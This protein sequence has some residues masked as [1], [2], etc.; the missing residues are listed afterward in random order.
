[1]EKKGLLQIDWIVSFG[2]FVVLL[3]LIFILFGPAL[4]QEYSDDYLKSIA[5]KGFK[6]VSYHTVYRYP[7]FIDTPSEIN[8]LAKYEVKL[9]QE[10]L[11]I[12]VDV[13]NLMVLDN[14]TLIFER[15][16]VGDM[17]KF[18]YVD[19]DPAFVNK[20]LLI[21][22]GDFD[23]LSLA[24]TADLLDPYKITLGVRDE[25]YVFSES[26][27][28]DIL[29]WDYDIFKEELKYPLSKDVAV[30]IY[31][32]GESELR[33]DAYVKKEPMENDQVFVIRWFDNFINETTG[34]MQPILINMRV[35]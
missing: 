15:D 35:W 24:V 16:I 30:Y 12:P 23:I 33:Y 7:I 4:T 17:L 3:L 19:K 34:R 32:P 6:D 27:F 22:S 28:A 29:T 8:G 26:R 10:L 31:E 18:E 9:P 13:K 14:Q 11:D 25:H 1:M 21:Y 20:L 5:Q 2:I